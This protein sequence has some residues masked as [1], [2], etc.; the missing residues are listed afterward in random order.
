VLYSVIGSE[1]SSVLYSV[2]GSLFY[3]YITFASKKAAAAPVKVTLPSESPSMTGA[4]DKLQQSRMSD[5]W[6]MLIVCLCTHSSSA[7]VWSHIISHKKW[8]CQF[9]L[10]FRII[11]CVPYFACT[12]PACWCRAVATC[13]VKVF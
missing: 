8:C 10:T 5:G 11:V 3:S 2:I 4:S 12:L 13:Q 7:L 9:L 6:P 1:L